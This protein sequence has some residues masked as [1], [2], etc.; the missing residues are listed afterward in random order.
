MTFG[1]AQ[2]LSEQYYEFVHELTVSDYESNKVLGKFYTDCGIAHRMIEQIMREID[3]DN[4]GDSIK[5]IDPFC[6]DGRL[7]HVFL[8][9]LKQ[10][11][12][13]FRKHIDITVWDI[14]KEAVANA[15][16]QT[17]EKIKDFPS[18]H[19]EGRSGDAFV[20]YK[21]HLNEYDICLTNPPW[22]ILKPQKLFRSGHSDEQ[23][24]AYKKSI[25]L[26]DQYMKLEFV[27]AM[28]TKKFGAWGTNLARCGT[29]VALCL[30]KHDGVCG[31]VSP[32]SL[33]NDQVSTTLRKWL[34]ENFDLSSIAFY[35]AEMK[36]FGS[37]DIAS[38]T[39][40]LYGKAKG[41]VSPLVLSMYKTNGTVQEHIVDDSEMQFIAKKGYIFPFNSG[42][43][44]LRI[45]ERV[46]S[47]PSLATV[48]QNNNLKFTREIDETRISEK[49]D[50]C[51]DIVFAKGYMVNRYSFLSDG[52]YLREDIKDIPRSVESWK[53]VWRDVSRNSQT[54][55][56]KATLLSPLHICGNSLGIIA[57]TSEEQIGLLKSLLGIM[58]SM[59][60]EYLVRDSLVTNH[61]PA[62]IV[63]QVPVPEEPINQELQAMVDSM[64]KGTGNQWDIEALVAE[65]YGISDEEFAEITKSFVLSDEEKED[66]L[67]AITQRKGTPP[68]I[69]NHY[70]AKLSDLDMQIVRC[71]PPGGNWKNIPESVPSHRLEQIRE[72]FKAGK[73]SRSTYYGRL[74][75]DMP[76]YTINTYFNRPGNGCHMHYEQDRTISQREAARFQSFPDSF[77]FTGSLGAINNQIGNAVP[78]LLAY[79]VA[80]ALPFKGQF[81]DLF[82]GAG[83]LALG[84][85]W[86]GWKP[87]ISNDIDKYAIETHHTNIEEPVVC[88]DINSDE[89]Y[90]TIVNAALRARE[91]NPDL[92]LFVL[93]G[94]PCQGFS[95]ANTRRGADDLRNWLFKA[96]IRIVNAIKPSG[97]V[98]ENVN[99]ITNLDG[100][101]F[102]EMIKNELRE[103]IESIKV[104]K[105]NAAE[106][107]IPQ[108]RERVIIIGGSN[109]LTSNFSMTPI[110]AVKKEAQVSFLQLPC[111]IGAKDAI[112]DL[113]AIEHSQ[114]GSELGYRCEPQ[115]AYQQ[116]MR[117]QISADEYLSSYSL[118]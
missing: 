108:R 45:L 115:S 51:G 56:I 9:V 94:P 59:V 105:V 44:A 75:P 63:K 81:V 25:A 96:Y 64:L 92:P 112:G 14:D 97:F 41:T 16:E 58:N 46:D 91:E 26:Y 34:F 8:D 74:L 30:I 101:R 1:E 62:G 23:I 89:V 22:G 17:L 43:S 61:V 18:W 15:T 109:E 33:F 21:K 87:I 83:G 114:D 79:Q 13:W 69:H 60:F 11:S 113:P 67:C 19:V 116:F 99:G 65:M 117:G 68:V 118:D 66:L 2:A 50:S 48:C 24:E 98:F 84:F 72:S 27:E 28:P 42:I 73:G 40:I 110:T 32:A 52:M 70:A 29:Q 90:S 95:T 76:S 93:G 77:I 39:A 57:S 36:L 3:P 37:A 7:I 31:I 86:A 71:V 100:G 10:D 4:F 55:R 12:R 111:V 35:P 82:C 106:F 78:P 88:G 20:E 80:K 53:I 54:R 104:N 6:G 47:L 103:C 102:F 5:I 85:I 49:L 38:I 107:G